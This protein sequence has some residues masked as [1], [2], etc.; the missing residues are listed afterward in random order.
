MDGSSLLKKRLAAMLRCG[1]VCLSKRADHLLNVPV[2]PHAA[3]QILATFVLVSFA[4]IFFRAADVSTAAAIIGSI[5]H[6]LY[7]SAAHLLGAPG[8]AITAAMTVSFFNE[9]RFYF[10]AIAVALF[11]I[12]DLRQE[13]GDIRFAEFPRW[14]RW[15]AYYAACLTIL[16]IGNL[17][18]KQFIYFQF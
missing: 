18:N 14:Q 6:S 1:S 11:M 9:P 8:Q 3:W 16:L 7:D 17:G 4:W 15:G 13:R 10:A 12:W 2:N 5:G